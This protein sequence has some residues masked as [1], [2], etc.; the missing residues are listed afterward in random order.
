MSTQETP[1]ATEGNMTFL[2]AMTEGCELR[3]FAPHPDDAHAELGS[4]HD[5]KTHYFAADLTLNGRSYWA[6]DACADKAAWK[7][8]TKAA[9]DGAVELE[10][11]GRTLI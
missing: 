10:V 1:T 5:P 7:A 2:E 9:F 8:Y 6:V 3:I 4:D 11:L